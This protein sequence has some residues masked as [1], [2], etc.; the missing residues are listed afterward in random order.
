MESEREGKKTLASSN[1]AFF[2][3]KPRCVFFFLK[4]AELHSLQMPFQKEI[5]I[6]NKKAV[7]FCFVLLLFFPISVVGEE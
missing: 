5:N 6:D 3:N 2:F 1:M 7:P 4:T